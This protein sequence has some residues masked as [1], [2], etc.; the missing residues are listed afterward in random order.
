MTAENNPI[1]GRLTRGEKLESLHRGAWVLVGG[2][3]EVL[4]HVGDPQQ[5]VFPRSATKSIQALPLIESGA[6]DTAGLTNQELALAVA[7]HNGEPIHEQ[8]AAAILAKVGLSADHLQCGEAA[9]AIAELNGKK[10]R[11]T[12]NCSGKHAGY[13]TTAVHLGDD[14]NIYLSPHSQVQLA[15]HQAVLEMTGLA[16]S[17]L[18]L[19][20][21][22]C[23]APTFE[24]PL[25]SLALGIQRMTNPTELPVRRASACDRIVQASVTHPE[26]VAGTTPPRFDTDLMRATNGRIFSKVGAEG[27]QTFG[28]VGEGVG[29]AAKMDD[30]TIRSLSRLT[31]AV[32]GEFGYLDARERAD[33]ATW[34]D[35]VIRNAAGIEVGRH[36]L[37]RW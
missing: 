24:M 28:V 19:A 30:G 31:L 22:G 33:L 21:D 35:P 26:M 4:A 1:I 17:D 15:V 16:A 29:F 14:P 34:S 8:A 6:A 3:G 11:I 18:G 23:S 12:H 13:L 5:R 37:A 27:V 2:N 9:P 7:S 32:L 10:A 36:T 20:I 25:A